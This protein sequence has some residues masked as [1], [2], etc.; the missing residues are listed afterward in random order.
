MAIAIEGAAHGQPWLWT[1]PTYDQVRIGWEESKRAA[2]SVARFT[3]DQMR[4]VFPSGGSI[5]YR[6]LDNPDNARGHTAAGVIMDEASV[7][8]EEAWYEVV[9]PMLLDTGGAAWFLFTP[10]GRGWTWREFVQAG[11]R[12]DSA[13][14]QVP[15]LG[16]RIDSSGQLQRAPHPL[17]N[18]NV[19]FSEIEQLWRT[20]PERTFRQE[21]L[22]EFVQDAG[23]VFR[24]V[25][26]AATATEQRTPQ[27]GHEYAFG[28]DWAKSADFTVITVLDLTDYSVALK[29]RFNQIDYQVQLGRLRAL[30]ERFQPRVVVPERNSIGEPLIEQLQREG[31]RVKPFTTTSASKTV[32]IDALALAFEKGSIRIPNDP[33]LIAELEAYEMERTQAGTLRYSA[34]SGMHD[35][36]VIS[37]ALAWSVA[38]KPAPRPI[39]SYQG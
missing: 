25:R 16:C 37:L 35:D 12:S 23:G 3:Q 2:G 34:P 27:P 8:R 15:T 7:V 17:E 4:A 22:A 11:D 31:M 30:Y 26:E 32:L 39:R 38:A 20:M 21:I 33:T 5:L 13:A 6:S 29:D 28:V 24:R 14:W 36:C 1:A 19:P 10:A 18:P 9:R